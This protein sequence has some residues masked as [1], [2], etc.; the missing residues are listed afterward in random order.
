MN[1]AKGDA[2]RFVALEEQYRKAPEVT[3]T[4]IYQETLSAVLP[5]VGK[6]LIFDEKARGTCRCF[7]W[8]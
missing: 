4:R 7:R 6:K 2:Q 8:A 1:R 5:G 3:R